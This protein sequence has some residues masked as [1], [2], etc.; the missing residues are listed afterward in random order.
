MDIV[1]ARCHQG[2]DSGASPLSHPEN[3]S[4]E[5]TEPLSTARRGLLIRLV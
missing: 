2:A 4:G 5:G 1:L 3:Y